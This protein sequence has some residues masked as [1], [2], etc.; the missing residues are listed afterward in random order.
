MPPPRRK[1]CPPN[2]GSSRRSLRATISRCSGIGR[3]AQSIGRVVIAPEFDGLLQSR[4]ELVA[5][6]GGRA[7]AS[8]LSTVSLAADK[9]RT[10]EHLRAKG[11][12]APRGITMEVGE[13]PLRKR[14]S[15]NPAVL[16]PRFGAGSQDVCWIASHAESLA[17]NPIWQ[18]VRLEEFC[19]GL[20]ASVA[21]LCGSNDRL[22]LLPCTQRLSADGRFQYLGGRCPL[23]ADL[24]ARAQQLALRA[25]NTLAD[26]LGYIGVDLVLGDDPAG[27]D[28]RVIE[29]NPRLTTSYVGLR[30]MSKVNLAGALLNVAAGLPTRLSWHDRE[31][32]F[33]S[34]GEVRFLSES[35]ENFRG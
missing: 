33:A 2:A 29:I 9:H 4:L 31:V 6:V 19:P 22:P 25:V 35:V 7:L 32:E 21:I 23:L 30:A 24:V 26:P 13:Y 28:D 1:R 11:V 16:K 18:P 12:P 15:N 10:A 14:L 3:Q 27:V 34:T 8:P 17:H 20:A 5:A